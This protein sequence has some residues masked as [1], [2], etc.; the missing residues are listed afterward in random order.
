MIKSP[1]V[2]VALK[3]IV[4]CNYATAA[5]WKP[6]LFS[7]NLYIYIHIYITPAGTPTIQSEPIAFLAHQISVFPDLRVTVF[8]V[9]NFE[10]VPLEEL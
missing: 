1:V 10:L 3:S 4:I 8:P 5:R 6:K 9:E 7:Q 2:T